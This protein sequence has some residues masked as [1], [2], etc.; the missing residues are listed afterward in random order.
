LFTLNEFLIWSTFQLS[1][2]FIFGLPL[3]IFA[4]SI[5]K[6]NKAVEKLLS[7]YWKVSLLYFIS[8]ILFIG[9]VDFALLIFNI[10]NLLITISIWFWSDINNELKEYK[11]SHYLTSITKIWRWGITFISIIF[12]LKSFQN[13]KCFYSVQLLSCNDW[14]EP[15]TN[16]FSI[17]NNLFNFLFGASFTEPIAKF[18]GLFALLLYTIG[19]FQWIII[20]LPKNGRNSQ[21]SNYGEN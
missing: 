16:L 19:L 12:L 2:I 1:I 15:S 13:F 20:K 6:K 11:L 14:M 18:I 9:K 7:C 3:S 5:K 10:S 8:L 21:F 17:I 4:W